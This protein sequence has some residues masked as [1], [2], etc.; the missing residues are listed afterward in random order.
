MRRAAAKESQRRRTGGGGSERRTR[1]LVWPPCGRLARSGLGL[2]LGGSA[3]LPLRPR[4][5]AATVLVDGLGCGVRPRPASSRPRSDV[6]CDGLGCGGLGLVGATVSTIA[7]TLGAAASAAPSAASADGLAASTA[8]ASASALRSSARARQRP[9]AAIGSGGSSAAT[10]S[11]TLRRFGGGFRCR[12][13]GGLGLDDC[14]DFGAA[15]SASRRPRPAS[16]PRPGLGGRFLGVVIGDRRP[17]RPRPPRVAGGPGRRRRRA[18]CRSRPRAPARR[19]TSSS[20]ARVAAVAPVAVRSARRSGRPSGLAAGPGSG[21]GRAGGSSACLRLRPR[22]WRSESSEMILSLSCWPSW[23]TSPGWATR[24]WDSSLM[25]I[26]PSSPS[27]TRTNAPKLTSLVT[28]PSM[29]S[30]TLKSA[31]VECHGSGWSR[32][33]DRLIRPRSWLMSMTSASTSSPT[34]VAGLGVVDLVPRQLALVDEAVDAAE[35][36]E[37]AERRDRADRAG[38]LLADLQAAEQLVAL[39]APLF[40]EGDLLRQ[41][42]PVGLAVDLEDLEPELATDERQQL[43]GD[44]LRRVARLVVLRP[45]REVHDLADRHEAAD[46]AVDDQAALVVV[47]DRSLDDD[48]RL[49]LLLHGAPLALQAGA[50]ERQD[51]VALGRLGLEDVDQDRVAD[52][53][54]RLAL[55]MATEQL[56]IA[57]DAFALGADV[58]Q[59]LVLVD[60]DDLALDDIAVLEALD[61]RV[62]LG[63]ELLHRRRLRAERRGRARAPRSSSLA[64]GASAVSSALSGI[65]SGGSRRRPPRRRGA[66][67]AAASTAVGARRRPGARPRMPARPLAAARPPPRAPPR[68]GASS[69]VGRGVVSTGRRRSASGAVRRG[70]SAMVAGSSRRRPPRRCSRAPD[71]RR[72]RW[73][74]APARSR[75]AALRSRVWSLLV[76]DLR[77][78][79]TNGLSD[80]QAVFRN[81]QVVRG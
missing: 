58:D 27:R 7:S 18:C 24:W 11:T 39:L 72:W 12:F 43:L 20:C 76:V 60:P 36:D 9:A 2:G 44:L 15:A 67:V 40:V 69:G 45:A 3:R 53:Q 73:P 21:A 30:P 28:V 62:L 32:R 1:R 77:P 31:T 78:R 79:I 17:R 75:P 34:S 37:H 19:R 54:L 48:A 66:S 70:S 59:D 65:D 5:S 68:R 47:D 38:D 57:D 56:A 14:L 4:L 61:V 41:D 33:I 74:P 25:W 50:A 26:R 80:A 10:V 42:Q 63:Q 35:I 64:A 22:R 46:A 13:G 8:A 52:G 16:P 49:E 51:D 29:M 23:T 6:G 55:A 71:R 81:D